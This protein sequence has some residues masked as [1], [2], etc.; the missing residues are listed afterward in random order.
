MPGKSLQCILFRAESALH[1]TNEL[2]G[3][4]PR[5]NH[6][7]DSD[8][9][10]CCINSAYYYYAVD[11]MCHTF[12]LINKLLEKAESQERIYGL[13]GGNDGGAVFLSA[14][15]FN[16]IKNASEIDD[17]DKPWIPYEVKAQ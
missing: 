16:I 6:D 9:F 4:N 5:R 15:Q 11:G 7:K 2:K 13:Y 1:K 8:H 12:I 3:Y 10:G 17:A 14:E